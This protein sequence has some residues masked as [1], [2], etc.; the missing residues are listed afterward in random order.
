GASGE[1]SVF[2]PSAILRGDA[3]C[4]KQRDH[5]LRG[6]QYVRS[7]PCKI[8]IPPRGRQR[9][10]SALQGSPHAP[11]QARDRGPPAP[12]RPHRFGSN[13]PSETPAACRGGLST[14]ATMRSIPLGV[15]FSLLAVEAAAQQEV[16]HT[17]V[18]RFIGE[19]VT[20]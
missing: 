13:F 17:R 8:G 1:A 12:S 5:R 6:P 18:R 20:V 15:L 14:E 4:G 3:E 19:E 2:L 7:L 9:A 10:A 16:D 11:L